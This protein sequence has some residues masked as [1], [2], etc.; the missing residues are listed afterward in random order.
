MK[1]RVA[2]CQVDMEWEHTARNLERLEPIVAAADADIAVL[3]EMFATGFKLR[4]A[5]VAE[6]ADGLVA[7]TMRRWAAQYGKA[8]VGSVVIAENGEFRNR[9]F[10]VKPSGGV[11]WYDKRHLFRPGGEA[12]DYTP[13]DR[14]V[15]VEY[16][17]FRFLLLIC[18]DL[19]FPVW[20]RNRG[21]YDMILY[22]ANWPT[23]R[24]SA[25]N[26][27][28]R[29]RAVENQCYVAGVNRTGDDPAL[30]YDGSSALIGFLGETVAAATPGR[31]EA[32]QGEAD[33][34]ALEAFRAKFPALRDADAFTLIES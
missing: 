31:E 28:L 21:D 7:T 15:V 1:I 34:K 16:M 30:V 29:A 27:L 33:L 2:V 22:V 20:S 17:G 5:R 11:A 8:V 10:F 4:P 23:V 32:V 18:Y 14:R 3:P 6:P 12:R 9:M 19:R 25:W 24:I 13:G 26:A